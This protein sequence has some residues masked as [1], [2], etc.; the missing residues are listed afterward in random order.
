MRVYSND[1]E[2]TLDSERLPSLVEGEKVEFESIVADQ[3]FTDPPPRYGEASL[4]K[5]LEEYGIGRP[6][7]YATIIATLIQRDYVE[8]ENKRFFPTDVGKL[9]SGFLTNHFS[10]YVDYEFTAQLEDALDA[11]SRGERDWI[12]LL[13]EFWGPFEE[14]VKTKETVSR[15]EVQQERSLG[16]HPAS[17]KPVSVRMGRYGP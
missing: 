17:G 7:T 13:D 4:V 2:T 14:T 3:H 8:L 16:L 15:K 12:S 11:V 1:E 9:V 6:S 10:D 5:T